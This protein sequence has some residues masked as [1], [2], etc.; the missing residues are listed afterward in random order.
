[1][2]IPSQFAT[3]FPVGIVKPGADGVSVGGAEVFVGL[4]VGEGVIVGSGVE[5]E[6]GKLVAVGTGVSV[7][8]GAKVLHGVNI[9]SRTEIMMSLFMT[10]IVSLAYRRW[11][12]NIKLIFSLFYKPH[13]AESC[14]ICHRNHPQHQA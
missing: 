9:N 10:F 14:V 5:V 4:S 7:G 11:S 8:F 2:G 1:M 6:V 13:F 12:K 3:G